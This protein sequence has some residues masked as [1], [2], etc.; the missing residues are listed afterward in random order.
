MLTFLSIFI[1][2]LIGCILAIATLTFLMV[3][4]YLSIRLFELILNYMGDI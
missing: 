2:F 1:S 3:I 4:G